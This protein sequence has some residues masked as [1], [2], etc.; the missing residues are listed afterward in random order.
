MVDAR[1]DLAWSLLIPF[2]SAMLLYFGGSRVLS[3]MQKVNAGLLAPS[4]ALTVGDLVM[5]LSYLAA[6]LGP[7]G[8]LASSAT[9]LQNSLS[10]LDR[11]LDILAEPLEM[12][13]EPGES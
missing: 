4:K 13:A 8:S 12:P 6:L 2:A 5:F 11:V 7:L 1:I 9:A 10:G 3:D